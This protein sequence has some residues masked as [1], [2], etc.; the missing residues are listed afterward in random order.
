MPYVNKPRPYKH[1]YAMQKKRNEEADRAERQRARREY[2]KKG[3]NR[4]GK[5]IAHK[6]ALVDGGSNADGT[7]LESPHANRSYARKSNHK[8]KSAIDKHFRKKS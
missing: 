2:D 5:D 6:K 3:I 1:E 8:P 4:K 7:Q